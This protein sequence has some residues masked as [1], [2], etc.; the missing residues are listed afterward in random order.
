[1]VVSIKSQRCMVNH[2]LARMSLRVVIAFNPRPAHSMPSCSHALEY[3][4]IDLHRWNR[5]SD[6][7]VGGKRTNNHLSTSRLC[8]TYI[9][10]ADQAGTHAL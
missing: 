2:A 1:M 3:A 4:I 7:T 6:R 10:L 9:G 8:L 5:S